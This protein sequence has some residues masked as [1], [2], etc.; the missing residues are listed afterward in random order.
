MFD[1]GFSLDQELC[2]NFLNRF[3]GGGGGGGCKKICMATIKIWINH[4]DDLKSHIKCMA[5]HIILEKYCM[6]VENGVTNEMLEGG[7]DGEW[8]AW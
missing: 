6:C 2:I 7:E 3:D 4:Y 1:C 8:G 5:K